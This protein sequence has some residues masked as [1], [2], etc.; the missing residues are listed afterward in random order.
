[1]V[2][3][4]EFCIPRRG[5]AREDGVAPA[6]GYPESA[7]RG[8]AGSSP[9]CGESQA[10]SLL[11]IIRLLRSRQILLGRNREGH[12]NPD[13]GIVTGCG[14]PI[15]WSPSMGQETVLRQAC[16]GRGSL[17]MRNTSIR[18]PPGAGSLLYPFSEGLPSEP[19]PRCPRPSTQPAQPR[20]PALLAYVAASRC[21]VTPLGAATRRIEASLRR[22]TR[23]S[24]GHASH[25][26]G[27]LGC[28]DPN[29]VHPSLGTVNRDPGLQ[30]PCPGRPRTISRGR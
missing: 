21:F 28:G 29:Y 18:W 11:G 30:G 22:R 4:E 8:E 25:G 27:V 10:T 3:S 1:L 26:N 9:R 12:P 23:P 13:S 24:D 17:H 14:K 16:S 19:R 7:A 2:T 15:H 5:L 6:C 20:S